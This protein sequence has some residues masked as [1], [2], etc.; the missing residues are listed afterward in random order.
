[1][2]GTLTLET[3]S[4]REN[5]LRNATFQGP[6]WIPC[7]VVIS[8]GTWNQLREEV[9]EV[10][11]R[12]PILFPGFQKGQRDFDSWDYGPGHRAHQRFT[13]A[14]GCV[15]EAS[16]EGLEG[17]VVESPLA[18]WSALETYQPPDP[19]VQADRGPANW[20][21]VRKNVAEAKRAG[22]LT[23]GS[24]PHGFLLM[25]MYYLR[26]FENLMLDFALESPQLPRL[27]EM[28]VE[29]NR[30]IVNEWLSMGVDLVN[31]GEDLGSQTASI[32][33]PRHFA[34]WIRPAYEKLIAP[35]AEKGI[36]VALHSDG[37][38]MDLMDEFRIAGVN[39]INPQDLVNGIDNLA[40]EVKGKFCIRLDI[41]R[42]KIVPFGTR[43][44]IHDLIEEEVRKLGSPQGGLEMICG[45]YPPTPAENVDAVLEAMKEFR[46]YWWDGR[47]G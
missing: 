7:T 36:L 33:G 19:L 45:I 1:M 37:Y 39:I 4:E 20:E 14:W 27:I 13:D 32:I 8:G 5:F 34:R 24:T 26:G 11:V 28:L 6:Q 3:L 22:R 43:Q 41:D 12:H 38:I 31:I 2:G 46:T 29:H 30:K 9:E 10:L 35:C 15:W 16:L 42:Q 25:R 17:L 47:G 40:R 18:D 21:Q 23:S 44:D